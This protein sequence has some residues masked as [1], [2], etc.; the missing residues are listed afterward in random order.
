M[1]KDRPKGSLFRA[2]LALLAVALIVGMF[3]TSIL[4]LSLAHRT[5]RGSVVKVH[6]GS[7]TVQKRYTRLSD[8]GKSSIHAL[9][10]GAV[11]SALAGVGLLATLRGGTSDRR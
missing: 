4:C 7:G 6:H 8:E 11:V 1:H 9:I 3:A 10:G 5:W 2:T